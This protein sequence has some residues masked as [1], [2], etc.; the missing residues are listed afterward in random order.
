MG[1]LWVP[2]INLHVVKTA[3]EMQTDYP[4]RRDETFRHG[5]IP[6]KKDETR[7]AWSC[8]IDSRISLAYAAGEDDPTPLFA[9]IFLAHKRKIF[10]TA[11]DMDTLLGT[12]LS[13]ERAVAAFEPILTSLT[14][15]S[16]PLD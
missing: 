15:F 7:L 9:D 6:Y 4:V 13:K 14:Q 3:E 12:S 8:T 16:L 5:Y 10:M 1:N 11:A 2:S